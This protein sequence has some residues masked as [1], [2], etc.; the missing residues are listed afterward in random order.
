VYSARLAELQAIGEPM[1]LR[2]RESE[3]REPAAQE[4]RRAVQ[5]WKAWAEGSEAAF[6]HISA[7][8]K[9]SVK[10]KAVAAGEWLAEGLAKQ[11]QLA[12]H[13]RP[14]LLSGDIAARRANLEKVRE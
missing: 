5:E 13:D 14:A 11:A 12:P 4:L 7:E 2:A 3:E 1:E 6:D 10:S 8:D 9:A